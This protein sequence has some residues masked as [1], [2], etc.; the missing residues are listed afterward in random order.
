MIDAEA[1]VG[2]MDEK[3]YHREYRSNDLIVYWNY[4]YCSHS[5]KCTKLLPQVFDMSKR[6]WVTIDGAEPLDIIA[7]IDKCPTGALK[8]RLTEDSAI[9]PDLA[10]GPGSMDYKVSEPSIVQIRMVKGGPLLVKGPAKVLD[11]DGKSLRECESMVLCRCGKSKNPPFCDG[12]HAE[13]REVN[14]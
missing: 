6:P 8:Y 2:K 12:S 1:E 5:G 10:R 3:K 11:P 14:E 4:G 13:N 7:A 9:D